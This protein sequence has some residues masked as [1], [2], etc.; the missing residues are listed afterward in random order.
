MA[1]Q[2]AARAKA[3]NDAFL[4]LI[5]A[6]DIIG[7]SGLGGTLPD[8]TVA[9]S[10]V[11]QHALSR[12]ANDFNSFA[13]KAVPV[14]SDLMLVEDSEAA[15]VKKY[16]SLTSLL[17]AGGSTT[18]VGLTDTPSGF[19]TAN[20]LYTTNGTPDAMVETTVILTEGANTFNVA[21]GTASLDIA[22]GSALDVN[23]NLTVGGVSSINQNV[24]TTGDPTF[25]TL[26]STVAIGTAPL[27]VTS[28]TVVTNLNAD[29]LDAQEGAY[30][31]GSAN[32]TGTSWVALTDSG[33]TAL[34]SHAV[35]A[36]DVGLGNVANKLQVAAD[37][38]QALTA[39]WDAGAFDITANLFLGS[40]GTN[41]AA[42]GVTFSG[43]SLAAD[44][45]DAAIDITIIPKGNAGVVLPNALGAPAVT[46]NKLYQTGG[47]IYFDGVSL[48]DSGITVFTELTDTPSGFTTAN[49]LYSTNGTPDA[50]IE[51]TVILTEGTNTFNVTKGTASLDIAAGSVLN[52][53]ANLTVSGVSDIDQ[54]V[55]T[56]ASP[57]YAGMTL[58]GVLSNTT[59]ILTINPADSY[60]RIG[61]ANTTSHTLGVDDLVVTGQAEFNDIVHFDNNAL[62]YSPTQH[63]DDQAATFG[64]SNDAALNYVTT[65]GDAVA[66]FRL[67]VP[68]TNKT[69]SIRAIADL[70]S[71]TSFPNTS[72][73]ALAIHGETEARYGIMFH[74]ETDFIIE[75]TYGTI[76]FDDPDLTVPLAL[77][78]GSAA[79]TTTAQDIVG[80]IN[81]LATHVAGDG[82]DH[83]DV[84][85]L[86]TLSGVAANSTDLGTFTGTTIADS[87]TSKQALQALETAVEIAGGGAHASSHEGGTDGV[88]PA[89]QVSASGTSTQV[90]TKGVGTAISWEDA[91]GA[92]GGPTAPIT[93]SADATTDNSGPDDHGLQVFLLAGSWVESG[94][95]TFTLGANWETND[96]QVVVLKR[97]TAYNSA[98]T[99]VTP[100]SGFGD[101]SG[102]ASY[103]VGWNAWEVFQMTWDATSGVWWITSVY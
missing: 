21:K 5:D 77:N 59:G 19:T 82:S 32:F 88:D 51:T 39:D 57:T 83:Q 52:V 47:V 87:Q 64:S 1:I 86:V 74:D 3:K 15:G 34:H 58:D 60:T 26:T 36:S 35:T 101:Y 89:L 40:F 24:T 73:P 70:S 95:T 4:G 66:Q 71:V 14:A 92:G 22:A 11:T 102:A 38:T 72:Y 41:V 80:A 37:G 56:T 62:F 46:S 65:P 12:A 43:T 13:L 30:Y 75:S 9:E 42:A 98:V 18:F 55:T 27:A 76:N 100:D 48:E 31:L 61:D 103:G 67:G 6:K 23:A 20:A 45:T 16:I 33:E 84:V 78:A 10:N 7:P 28:T 17:S 44:G 93:V 69:F 25:N 53:D 85:D 50:M 68:L 99:T 2:L 49:A 81:E 79:I 94:S 96:G 90:L 97:C 54:D 29:L 8:E 91:G 63:F